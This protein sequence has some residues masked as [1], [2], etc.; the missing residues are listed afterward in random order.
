MTRLP[1]YEFEGTVR[2]RLSFTNGELGKELKNLKI[3]IYNNTTDKKIVSI[4]III[5][6]KQAGIKSQ[7]TI[8]IL[9]K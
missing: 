9:D 1:G 2:E 5:S 6:E 7:E 8:L 3:E 4:D